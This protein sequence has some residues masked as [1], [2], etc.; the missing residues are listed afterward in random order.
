MPFD[1]DSL[2]R[3]W[4]IKAFVADVDGLEA[5]KRNVFQP[6]ASLRSIGTDGAST[7]V[8][9]CVGRAVISFAEMMLSRA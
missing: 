7:Q 2:R 3:D 4:N 8:V 9:P 5:L 1:G 6:V